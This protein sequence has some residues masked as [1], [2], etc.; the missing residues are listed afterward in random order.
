LKFRY[1]FFLNRNK[2]SLESFFSD[3]NTV[4]DI[5]SKMELFCLY[6]LSEEAIINFLDSKD[7]S[8]LKDNIGQKTKNPITPASSNKAVK[9]AVKKQAKARRPRRSRKKAVKKNDDKQKKEDSS[10]FETWKV[11]Y[12]EP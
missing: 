5:K 1:D 9:P 10:Y 2:L 6:G 12:V 3:C 7:N 8:A 4:A 11:P